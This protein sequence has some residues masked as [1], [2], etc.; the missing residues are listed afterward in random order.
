MRYHHRPQTRLVKPTL[1]RGL[2]GLVLLL[3]LACAEPE[4]SKALVKIANVKVFR[5]GDQTLHVTFDY[6]LEKG[7]SLP[8]PYKEVLVFPLDPKIK[9][10]GTIEP[11]VLHVGSVAVS[12]AIPPNAGIDWSSLNKDTCCIVSLK[13][14]IE[15][16]GKQEPRY[17]RISNEMRVLPPQ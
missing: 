2:V 7:V 16:T 14:L 5:S 4:T 13:G 10:G 1:Q 3:P 17:E 11:F 12:L 15:Q 8:L 9:L 6:D